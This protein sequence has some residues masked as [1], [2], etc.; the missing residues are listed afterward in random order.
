MKIRVLLSLLLFLVGIQTPWAAVPALPQILSGAANQQGEQ[1][2]DVVPDPAALRGDW[3][4]YFNV[5]PD[6]LA[7]RAARLKSLLER[8]Y[9]AQ[10][11]PESGS[12]VSGAMEVAISRVLSNLEAFQA[13]RQVEP[14]T[15]IAFSDLSEIYTPAQAL[16]LVSSLR[17]ARTALRFD[18]SDITALDEA[19]QAARRELDIEMGQ[20]LQLD[21]LDGSRVAV[22][23]AVIA[24]RL[25]L[26]TTEI[27]LNLRRAGFQ[28]RQHQVDSLAEAE[29]RA[30]QRLRGDADEALALNAGI[31]EAELSLE[32]AQITLSNEKRRMLQSTAETVQDQASTR[33]RQQRVTNASIRVLEARL[34]LRL[35]KIQAVLNNILLEDITTSM[36]D[37]HEQVEL[38]RVAIE[39]ARSSIESLA[40]ASERER[41]RA[42]E[43]LAS[44][45]NSRVDSL[46]MNQRRLRLAQESIGQLRLLNDQLV[47]LEFLT[48]WTRA[49]IRA[50]EGIV[51]RSLNQISDLGGRFSQSVGAIT[52]TTLFRLGETP[53]T[54]SGIFKVIVVVLI[55]WL[56]SW[57]FRRMIGQLGH[58]FP[59][60]NQS[61]LF[62]ISRLA[63]YLIISIGIFAGLSS[64]GLSFANFALVAGALALG[65]GFGLQSIVNNFLSGLILFFERTVKV[66][67]FVQLDNG[68]Q[69]E[70]RSINVRGTIVNTNDNVDVIVPNSEFTERKVVNWTLL[71]PFRRIHVPFRVAY[72]SN[73]DI[74]VEAGLDAANRLS[75]TLTGVLG[76]EPSVWLVNYGENGLDFELIVW[77]MPDAVK[78]PDAVFAAY[79]WEIRKALRRF[80]VEVPVP[81]R[82]IRF[83]QPLPSALEGSVSPGRG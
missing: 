76:R 9:L 40:A 78:R 3:W 4:A 6:Q 71:D 1:S 49:A 52:D 50:N 45:G 61:I 10:N 39:E 7:S 37:G 44:A 31:R 16:E 69:G 56:V 17:Q 46:P 77:L 54:L 13:A 66:G 41:D 47:K 28:V 42:G 8:R 23:L 81:Q 43:Q 75:S 68:E 62:V 22:G 32:T 53:I 30:E 19:V 36:R 14:P 15:P 80:E 58:R 12:P 51:D 55:A 24:D 79:H 18:K 48:R 38:T 57:I 83:R 70:V 25:A 60:D 73:E 67:D 20:Y 21:A 59:K 29:R 26:E 5:Q 74:V 34:K 82:E 63:H 27:Q 2:I 65:L 35:L 64:I 11:L 72:E 33:Y